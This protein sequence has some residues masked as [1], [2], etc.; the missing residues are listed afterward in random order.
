MILGGG[1]AAPDVGFGASGNEPL[2]PRTSA[3]GVSE[4][5]ALDEALFYLRGTRVH[6]LDLESKSDAVVVDLHSREVFADPRSPWLAYVTSKTPSNETDVDFVESPILHL[7]NI[8]TRRN[9]RVGRGIGAVWGPAAHVAYLRP[10]KERDC[11]GEVCTAPTELILRDARSGNQRAVL[12]AGYWSILGWS[13]ERVLV[14]D[15]DHLKTTLMVGPDGSVT[16]LRMTPSS[17][18]AGSPNGRWLL[19]VGEGSA[20][21]V[22]LDDQGAGAPPPIPL[23]GAVLAEGSWSS[24]STH[25]A[26]GLLDRR[27]LDSKLVVFGPHSTGLRRI[28]FVRPAGAV[29]WSPSMA[30]LVAVAADGSRGLRAVKCASDGS[31]GCSTLLRWRQ[32]VI[33]LSVR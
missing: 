25:I 13:G 10:V 23:S 17:L 16:K 20:E 12:P 18:W 31:S 4:A 8:V 9:V 7:F 27:R 30:S 33:L 6:R 29:L 5:G 22:S 14:A 21:F 28:G 3:S 32:G 1:C 19:A 11:S 2:V 15:A 24:D 26:A